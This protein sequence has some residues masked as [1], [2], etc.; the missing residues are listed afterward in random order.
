MTLTRHT[1]KWLTRLML[2]VMLF[3]QGV[4]AANACVLATGA[5]H[6][7]TM[8]AQAADDGVM[9]A[10][11]GH[12]HEEQATPANANACL[13]QNTQADQVSADHVVP[14]FALPVAVV[15]AVPA[16]PEAVTPP[17]RANLAQLTPPDTGPPLSIR[18][19]SL[20]N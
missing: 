16:A 9:D 19:C 1:V 4:V 3:S 5:T 20:L 15:L 13:A 12:C 17:T 18:F 7:Y 10:M 11:S 14:V 6:A 2:G 8:S